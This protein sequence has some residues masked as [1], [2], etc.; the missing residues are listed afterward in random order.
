MGGNAAEQI[1]GSDDTVQVPT[2]LLQVP[3]R[4]WVRGWINP[5]KGSSNESPC[6]FFCHCMVRNDH[7][8][9]NLKGIP[10]PKTWFETKKHPSDNGLRERRAIHNREVHHCRHRF[11]AVFES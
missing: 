6:K 9:V 1:P 5:G 11:F 3:D 4:V 7:T 10:R 2:K 8:P